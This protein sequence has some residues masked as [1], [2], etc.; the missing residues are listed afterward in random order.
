MPSPN[1]TFLQVPSLAGRVLAWLLAGYLLAAASLW[2]FQDDILLHPST[3][4]PSAAAL[5]SE[6]Q[7]VGEFHEPAG[8][9]RATVVFFHGNGGTV[10]DREF[11]WK[12][13][14][15]LGYRAVLLEYP[16]YG[17]RGGVAHA[18]DLRARGLAD[19]D[20]VRAR[21]PKEP[22][23]VAG[24][25]FGAGVAAAVAGARAKD[26]CSIVLIT[27]WNRLSELVQEKL[28]MFPARL[29]LEADYASDVALRAF[30]GAVTIVAAEQ[31][32]L[33][34]V[35]HARKLFEEH[36]AARWELLAG[37]GHDTWPQRVDSIT[38]QRWLAAD[39]RPAVSRE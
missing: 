25:S 11:V 18:A 7:Y 1:H 6:G 20:L 17:A 15:A 19:L 31:D 21:F 23:I 5:L 37:V 28:P 8:T 30:P 14:T 35:H 22:L 36:P 33:I 4:P 13:V 32:R 39:C 26:V 34:P 2:Y 27:P 12:S 3:A 24:E 38:W 16:G 10:A 29:L 9:A